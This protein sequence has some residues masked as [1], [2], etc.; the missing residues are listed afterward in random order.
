MLAHEMSMARLRDMKKH[1]MFGGGGRGGRRQEP[2][3][4]RRTDADLAN[5]IDEMEKEMNELRSVYELYYMGVEKLEPYEI[6]E[7]H[8][9]FWSFQPVVRPPAPVVADARFKANPVDRFIFAKYAEKAL[10]GGAGDRSGQ[11]DGEPFHARGAV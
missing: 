9:N 5:D 7:E 1:Q 11:P 2:E 10:R 4:N 6:S 3:D 8:R